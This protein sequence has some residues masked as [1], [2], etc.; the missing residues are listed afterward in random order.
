MTSVDICVGTILRY[1]IVCG[2][3]LQSQSSVSAFVAVASDI[4]KVKICV[5]NVKKKTELM[6][7]YH[8]SRCMMFN[9]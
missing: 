9:Y 4:V 6:E 5:Y 7:K 1:D 3:V 2:N 8:M